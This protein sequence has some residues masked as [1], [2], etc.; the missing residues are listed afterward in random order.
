MIY[1]FSTLEC[2]FFHIKSLFV[3]ITVESNPYYPHGQRQFQQVIST[4]IAVQIHQYAQ[5]PQHLQI[6]PSEPEMVATGNT[7]THVL[8][9]PDEAFFMFPFHQILTLETNKQ[10]TPAES[11]NCEKL[12]K[13]FEMHGSCDLGTLQN[14]DNFFTI[15]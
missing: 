10:D 15:F 1:L 12:C 14:F 5:Q 9:G 13:I 6:Q 3:Y 4:V 2:F 11:E 8:W 7:L